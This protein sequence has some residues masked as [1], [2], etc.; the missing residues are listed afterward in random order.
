MWIVLTF[1]GCLV[2]LVG[3]VGGLAYVS[4]WLKQN[5]LAEARKVAKNLA[6]EEGLTFEK[7]VERQVFGDIKYQPSVPHAHF[8]VSG[9]YRGRHIRITWE[10]ETLGATGTGSESSRPST[11]LCTDF[12]VELPDGFRVMSS[13]S[14]LGISDM[15]GGDGLE[16]GR[17][18]FDDDFQ[19]EA[20]DVEAALAYLDRDAVVDALTDLA[21]VVD[22][23]EI[24][25]GSLRVR[26]CPHIRAKEPLIRYLD[27]LVRC[28]NAL[29][30]AGRPETESG[31]SSERPPPVE[32]AIVEW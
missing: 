17:E 32:D 16:V 5:R 31:E 23:L 6:D 15:T 1:F 12:A 30:E 2:G 14:P 9:D 20:N 25:D 8:E 10:K 19:I 28:G 22:D 21:G 24:R 11:I 13:H 4:V 26:H 18:S 3:A 29:E 27:A 7:Q